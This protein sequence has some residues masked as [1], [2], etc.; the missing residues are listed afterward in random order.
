VILVLFVDF[1]HAQKI[2]VQ[3]FSNAICPKRL[4]FAKCPMWF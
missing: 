3:N 2:C 4:P 1:I